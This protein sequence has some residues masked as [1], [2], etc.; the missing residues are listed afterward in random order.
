MDFDPADSKWFGILDERQQK[1]V[2]FA[3]DYAQNYKHGTDGHN[4]LMTIALLADIATRLEN[5]AEMEVR[6]HERFD[7]VQDG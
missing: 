2:R 4:R 6:W 5:G 7:Q 1:E 3:L